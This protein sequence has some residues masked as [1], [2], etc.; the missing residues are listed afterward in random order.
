MVFILTID[1]MDLSLSSAFIC[2]VILQHKPRWLYSQS[3][4]DLYNLHVSYQ[5]I[6]LIKLLKVILFQINSKTEN[7]FITALMRTITRH[8]ITTT[9]QRFNHQSKVSSVLHPFLNL[10]FPSFFSLQSVSYFVSFMSVLYD[11]QYEV[12]YKAI[13]GV[14]ITEAVS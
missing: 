5:M 7:L 12:V 3:T 9:I 14:I 4:E 8:H 10:L 2:T 1:V 6:F 13:A 11:A